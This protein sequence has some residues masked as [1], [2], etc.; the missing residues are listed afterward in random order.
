MKK[1]LLVLGMITCMFGLTACGGTVEEVDN[2]GMTEETV[3]QY[4]ND[5]IDFVNYFTV[6]GQQ[7]QIETEELV[8]Y[9]MS[10]MGEVPEEYEDVLSAAVTSYAAAL[11]DMGDYQSVTDHEIIYDDGILMNVT[12]QGSLRPAK[13]EIMLNEDLELLNI[14]TNVVYTFGETMTKA[15]LN[16]LMGMGTVFAVLILIIALIS[17]FALIP[18]IQAAFSGKKEEKP[19][20]EAKVVQQIVKNEEVAYEDVTDDAELVAVIAAAIAAYVGSGSAGGYVV[21]SLKRRR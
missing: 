16:T 11:P 9:M 6:T 1:L 12:V 20:A 21:R 4:A 13:V 2:Y 14:S 18:K 8:Y 7:Q 19:A 15:A 3:I 5:L 17:S 10:S